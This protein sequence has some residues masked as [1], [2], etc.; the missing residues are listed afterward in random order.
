ME[1]EKKK[2]SRRWL[3]IPIAGLGVGSII[4]FVG[5]YGLTRLFDY[6]TGRDGVA[7]EII[8]GQVIYNLVQLPDEGILG[9]LCAGIGYRYGFDPL[10][11]RLGF[12]GLTLFGD[13]GVPLYIVT[14]WLVDEASTP[15]DYKLRIHGL[16][17]LQQGMKS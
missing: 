11:A 5:V 8:D 13:I 4:V 7:K 14:C 16:T 10:Y 12:I 15:D 2:R 17:P 9:G 6:K 1:G 3:F